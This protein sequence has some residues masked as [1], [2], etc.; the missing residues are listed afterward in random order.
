ML[1]EWYK[2]SVP[3]FQ[4]AACVLLLP[5]RQS[6]MTQLLCHGPMTPPQQY[7]VSSWTPA[8]SIYDSCLSP[9]LRSLTSTSNSLPA[10]DI[11]KLPC[12]PHA[13]S[14]SY[15][16][17]ATGLVFA[18]LTPLN[19]Y[20]YIFIY[21]HTHIHTGMCHVFHVLY[22]FYLAWQ[23][24]QKRQKGWQIWH[25]ICA[26]LVNQVLLG[27]ESLPGFL[28]VESDANFL[29]HPLIFKTLLRVLYFYDVSLC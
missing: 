29:I 11:S 6:T 2:K 19:M 14:V 27:A 18:F 21:R 24:I 17:F 15:S 23:M 5:H 1:H 12:F 25:E 8:P 22:L 26:D 10:L 28:L 13:P 9:V 20:R 4:W 16:L 3:D 7:P